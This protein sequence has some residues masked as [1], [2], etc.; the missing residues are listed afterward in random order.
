MMFSTLF[1]SALALVQ[2]RIDASSLRICCTISSTYV[3][4]SASSSL[5]SSALTSS[6]SKGHLGLEGLL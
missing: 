1:A 4:A 5:V 3:L 6:S 2:I